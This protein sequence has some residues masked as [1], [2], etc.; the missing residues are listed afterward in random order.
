M[1]PISKK[2]LRYF[3]LGRS[4]LGIIFAYSLVIGS[5]SLSIPIAV[6]NLVN[7]VAFGAVL[8]PVFVLT[9]IVF[10]GLGLSSA[11]KIAQRRVVEWL[12]MK[13]FY[14]TTRSLSLRL[15]E[16]RE[17]ALDGSYDSTYFSRYLELFS[18]QKNLS[19]LIIDVLDF[20]LVVGTGMLI[21][22]LYHPAFLVFDVLLAGSL[23]FVIRFVGRNGVETKLEESEKK[24]EIASWI[25]NLSRPDVA[26]RGRHGVD[27][28]VERTEALSQAFLETRKNHFAVLIR[29]HA[30]FLLISVLA[31]ALLLGVGGTLVFQ[32]QLS[33]GQLVAAEIILAGVLASIAKLD[34]IIENFYSIISSISKLESLF[35]FPVEE[36]MEGKHAPERL[37]GQWDF[38]EVNYGYPN[39][40]PLWKPVTLSIPA[41]SKIA[42]IGSSGSG[43]S[44][45]IEILYSLRSPSSGILRLDGL[46]VRDLDLKQVRDRIGFANKFHALPESLLSNLTMGKEIPFESLVTLSKEIGID[47]AI[48]NL[49][50]GYSTSLETMELPFSDGQ[51]SKLSLLRALAQD[52][53]LILIDEVLDDCDP[54]SQSKIL[55]C[56]FKRTKGKTVFIATHDDNISRRCDFILSLP[57][58]TLTEVRS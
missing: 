26:L 22:A 29:Q 53:D 39:R 40:A 58:G 23:L 52:P 16:V 7:S 24:Y 56:L 20:V 28:S 2:L 10:S 19:E 3:E 21:V 4:E 8:L 15:P 44:T 35:E 5:F 45:L 51:L 43:K 31:S 6:Q 37:K 9:L 42:L 38:H 57:A 18:L 11:M 17:D 50:D 55:D 49:P 54:E 36:S 14:R 32:H 13:M 41:G 30:G 34:K 25:M 33:L 27:L 1:N 47:E 12:T 48:Q 46:N